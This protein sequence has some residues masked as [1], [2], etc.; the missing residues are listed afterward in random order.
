MSI[1]KS[2]LKPFVAA[3]LKAREKI[4]GQV[5]NN[6]AGAG[7]RD[8]T[9]LRYTTGKNGWVRMI[10]MVDYNSQK[11][12]KD[13]GK[14]VDDKRY[15]DNQLTRKYI[16]EGGTLYEGDKGFYLRRG[17]NK[18]DGIYGSNID[19]INS[20]PK[21][22]TIDRLFG[23]RPMPGITSV[24]VQNKSAYGSLREATVNF[25]AWDKH[26]LEELEVLFMRPGYSVFLDWGWSQYLNH[27][28]AK[29]SINTCPDN[30]HIE[31]LTAPVP[32]DLLS[33]IQ[34]D[35]IY[36]LIDANIE[37]YNGNYDAMI[38]FVKNFSWQLMSNGGWQCST[39]IISRG[40][41]LEEIKASS[42][43]RTI[44]GSKQPTTPAA[45]LN[46]PAE[47]HEQ[48]FSFF[49][50][51]FLT[52][53]GA[54]N[55]SEFSDLGNPPPP[56]APPAPEGEENKTP[57]AP[58]QQGLTGEFY[59]QGVD[60]AAVLSKIADEF[61]FILDALREDTT[62]YKTYSCTDTGE[63]G[64]V[65]ENYGYPVN[66]FPGGVL[67]AEGSTDGSGIE[68][69]SLNLF[70]AILQRFFV[71][72]SNKLITDYASKTKKEI[73]EPLLYL[74][75]PGRT[76]CLM[77]E[78]TVSIDPTTCIFKNQYA[79]FITGLNDGFNPMLYT[80]LVWNG[81]TLKPSRVIKLPTLPLDGVVKDK[82][83]KVP[84]IKD[85][86]KTI[87][88]NQK[89][90]SIGEIGNIY[91]SIGK[92]IQ[93]YRDLA[94]P[95]GVNIVDLLTNILESISSALGGI[96]D[97]KLYTDKNIVQ[98]IDAKYLEIGESANNKF[99]MDIIGLKSVCRDVKIN[100][101]IFPE[102]ASMIAI[103]AAAGGDI[104]S[105]LGDI[106]ASTQALFNKG[107][108]DRVIR[109]LTFSEGNKNAPSMIEGQNLYYF[110]IYENIKA[111]TTYIKRKVIGVDEPAG[112]RGYNS[113]S[114]PKEEEISNASSLLKTLLYQLNG[115]DIDFKALIPFELEITLDGISGFV[116]GQIF[117]IDQSILPRDYYNKNLGFVVTGIS[118]MLQNNDWTTT[119]KTQI[120]LLENENYPSNVDKAQLKQAIETLKQQ[121][122]ARAYMFYAMVDY[123]IYLMIR[124][125]SDDGATKFKKPFEAG[126]K[127][128]INGAGM[129][130]AYFSPNRVQDALYRISDE[131]WSS[132]LGT[133]GFTGENYGSGL[134]DYMKKWWEIN[135]TNTSLP[136]F[137][138][139]SYEE[140]TTI[141]LPD[142]TKLMPAFVGVFINDFGKYLLNSK[143]LTK[144]LKIK[145]GFDKE[146]DFFIY[147]FFGKDPKAFFEKSNPPLVTKKINLY[148]EG[149]K[150]IDVIN[151]KETWVYLLGKVQDYINNVTQWGLLIQGNEA[152]LTS[153]EVDIKGDGQYKLDI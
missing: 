101:R 68:Y 99:K 129:D 22:N 58:Q 116:V 10:S 109:D 90:V 82:T 65:Y 62:K 145:D 114:T 14:W 103:G 66:N 73:Y 146:K 6:I 7:P 38:G 36:A 153:L 130:L 3:Q 53:K 16:L 93:T 119:I 147:K 19:K 92:I 67:P 84:D 72:R 140:F 88:I 141:I 23:I 5:D 149:K 17:V 133:Y 83:V 87:E 39:I 59:I 49:E 89:I 105:N 123:I 44:I 50:K 111:L 2:T 24:S 28:P 37:K 122:Q 31:N 118:H 64:G 45:G 125:M 42:N 46:T 30:I 80:N 132:E 43:P 71:P 150:E 41:A 1:F 143:N 108:K 76:P 115:K 52:L 34:E 121:N 74:V 124:I 78:D 79:S 117:T 139:G 137:P 113:V 48:P 110:Q 60:N 144:G 8:N 128:V 35:K 56:P 12:D 96:N 18:K 40:E 20:D 27:G 75:I 25:Y 120:C 21:S 11:F 131:K 138:T 102:Q 148:I 98:I 57:P 104:S 127:A 151:L 9:F 26:Q 69:I 85:Q 142:G 4:V 107:L 100:S 136:N 81:K 106:Y 86:E 70:V 54:L 13:K 63:I 91:I 47:L 97:F 135:S 77:S 51:L 134:Y 32:S 55:Q 112:T 95:N 61:K 15:V 152:P 126:T 94:G 33:S 29:Q